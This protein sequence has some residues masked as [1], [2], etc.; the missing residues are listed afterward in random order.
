M[1]MRC[2]RGIADCAKRKRSFRFRGI[3]R[4]TR[5]ASGIHRKWENGEYRKTGFGRVLEVGGKRRRRYLNSTSQDNN[6]SFYLRSP[7][8]NA[9]L[10]SL[11]NTIFYT[12]RS[13]LFLC[14]LVSFDGRA[15]VRF[16]R[17]YVNIFDVVCS[18]CIYVASWRVW[19]ERILCWLA[20]SRWLWS[21]RIRKMHK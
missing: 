17:Q 7:C 14:G 8:R 12:P 1:H 13:D 20:L 18:I 11:A 21:H 3:R 6:I 4:G 16:Q 10:F 2:A 15:R 5:F 19:W 9:S